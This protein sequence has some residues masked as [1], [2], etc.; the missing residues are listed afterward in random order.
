M[1]TLEV[2]EII[3]MAYKD[4]FIM[5]GHLRGCRCPGE[6]RSQGNGSHRI[7]LDFRT[8]PIFSTRKVYRLGRKLYRLLLSYNCGNT[9]PSLRRRCYFGGISVAGCTEGCHHFDTLR[10]GQWWR[11]RRGDYISVSLFYDHFENV[12]LLSLQPDEIVGKLLYC[13]QRHVINGSARLSGFQAGGDWHFG[14]LRHR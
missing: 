1:M 13:D 14:T 11:S 9:Y 5:Q 4:P 7:G 2:V 10:C 12:L 3:S 8:N 6:V